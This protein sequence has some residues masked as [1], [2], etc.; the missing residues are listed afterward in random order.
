MTFALASQFHLYLLW[1]NTHLAYCVLNVKALTG[2]LQPGKGSSR[3][4]LRE[5]ANRWIV[6]ISNSGK[7]IALHCHLPLPYLERVPQPGGGVPAP[8]G[9]G[10]E[11]QGGQEAGG[12][13]QGGGDHRGG[14]Q[15]GPGPGQVLQHAGHLPPQIWGGQRSVISCR[16]VLYSIVLHRLHNQFSQSRVG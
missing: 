14:G 16:V 2:R 5:C 15:Q 1:I 6:C 10:V 8:A 11:S 3:G 4:L 9:A 13:G 12:R 7:H